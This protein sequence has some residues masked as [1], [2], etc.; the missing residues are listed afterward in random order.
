MPT[1]SSAASIGRATCCYTAA[2]ANTSVATDGGALNA[3]VS[4]TSGLYWFCATQ[5]DTT[6]KIENI[7][8]GYN[9]GYTGNVSNGSVWANS[10]SSVTFSVTYT[11]TASTT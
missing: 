3:G 8:L 1:S 5:G 10:G 4:V 6:A 9:M 11:G 7:S 2:A